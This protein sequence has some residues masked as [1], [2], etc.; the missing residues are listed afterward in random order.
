MS[1]ANN[2]VFPWFH[3]YIQIQ[4]AQ[5]AGLYVHRSFFIQK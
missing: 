3:E 5:T 4:N 2:S 1:R